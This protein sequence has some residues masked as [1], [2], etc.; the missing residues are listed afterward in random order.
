MR[1]PSVPRRAAVPRAGPEPAAAPCGAAGPQRLP[2]LGTTKGVSEPTAR[3]SGACGVLQDESVPPT[4][5]HPCPR[6]GS[7]VAAAPPLRCS[8]CPGAEQRSRSRLFGTSSGLG[9]PPRVPAS[10]SPSLRMAAAC[11]PERAAGSTARILRAGEQRRTLICESV[12]P[13]EPPRF[14]KESTE[15]PG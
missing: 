5:I 1:D 14:A 2:Q 15:R 8:P 11:C 10:E 9:V 7:H 3:C 4:P 6:S 12:P 13:A